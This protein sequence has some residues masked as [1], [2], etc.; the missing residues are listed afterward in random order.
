[1]SDITITYRID[2]AAALRAGRMCPDHATVALT[3]ETM[4]LCTEQDRAFLA[5]QVDGG[6]IPLHVVRGTFEI[7]PRADHVLAPGQDLAFHLWACSKAY[8]AHLAQVEAQAAEHRARRELQ[9]VEAAREQAA[10]AKALADLPPAAVVATIPLSRLHGNGAAEYEARWALRQ[11]LVGN[12]PAMGYAWDHHGHEP[13]ARAAVAQCIERIGAAR[14]RRKGYRGEWVAR[15][16]ELWGR[17]VDRERHAAGVLPRGDVAAIVWGCVKAPEGHAVPGTCPG[18]DEELD[19]DCCTADPSLAPV[20]AAVWEAGHAVVAHFDAT[21]LETLGLR[22]T[23]DIVQAEYECPACD[24]HRRPE[25][26]IT[27]E[28]PH[29][30]WTAPP[31]HYPLARKGAA[32]DL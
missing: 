16:V 21:M 28:H 6:E 20:S 17:P 12:D 13:P 19:E 10:L 18:C 29:N 27:L 7:L 15:V 32:D 24:T 9:E 26:C 8:R 4:A 5:H 23:H 25:L 2:Q 30:G 1:M 11:A 14:E 3:P 22:L 31:R